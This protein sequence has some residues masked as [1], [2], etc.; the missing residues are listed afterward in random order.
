MNKHTLAALSRPRPTEEED[1]EAVSSA[2]PDV[3]EEKAKEAGKP[4]AK[5]DHAVLPSDFTLAP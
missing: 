3:V 4:L 5:L 1:A 2:T